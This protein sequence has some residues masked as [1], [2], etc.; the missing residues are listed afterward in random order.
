[1][2][3]LRGAIAVF[4]SFS[5]CGFPFPIRAAGKPLGLLTLVYNARLN[6]SEAFAGLSVFPGETMA[7][8]AD[9]KAMVR[10]GESVA[11][12]GADSEMTL[13]PFA[14]GAHVDLEAGS[15]SV[16]SARKNPIEVH[17]EDALLRPH[18]EQ[19]VQ[20]RVVLFA[21][22]VLQITTR[23]GSLEFSY[24][25]EFRVLPQ[26]QTYRLYLDAEA[27][28]EAQGPAGAGAGNSGATRWPGMSTGAKVAF[29][30]V[31]GTGVGLAAWGIHDIIQSGG[32]MESP[33]KP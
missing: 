6:A 31:L 10:I 19:D 25:G 27:G 17:A 22:K 29:F 30:I 13:E 33:A 14:T 3:S 1:M 23:A 12:L 5:L 4:V 24:R 7:T 11:T 9:G 26:G 2:D 15:V 32:G 18:G 21:P 16:F 20:A 8:D 28:P